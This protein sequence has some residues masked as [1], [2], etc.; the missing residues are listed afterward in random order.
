MQN[1][2]IKGLLFV[3]MG[4]VATTVSTGAMAK[5]ADCRLKIKSTPL[6][7]TVQTYR[8]KITLKN[9][10]ECRTFA[11]MHRRYYDHSELTSKEVEYIWRGAPEKKP[12]RSQRKKASVSATPG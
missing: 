10:N 11:E 3:I 7:G 6:N 12:K 1:V 5:D 9:A 2:K 8:F 4:L